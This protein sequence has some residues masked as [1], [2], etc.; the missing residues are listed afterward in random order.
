MKKSFLW[1]SA[2][3]LAV[4]LILNPVFA[5]IIAAEDDTMQ[6]QWSDNQL[7]ILRD[8]GVSETR[9]SA[10]NLTTGELSLMAAIQQAE[11]FLQ[12]RYPQQVFSFL[13]LS[14]NLL[15]GS[16]HVF[17]V[18]EQFSSVTFS[19]TAAVTDDPAMYEITES[20]Y[21]LTKAQEVND[22]LN[23]L[24][25]AKGVD[26]PKTAIKLLGEYGAAFDPAVPVADIIAQ[27]QLFVITGDVYI[28]PVDDFSALAEQLRQDLSACG[29]VGGLYLCMMDPLPEGEA[30]LSWRQTCQEQLIDRAFI[31]MSA[32][33]A[34]REE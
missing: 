2:V 22:Y 5:P 10:N 33:P 23:E 16:K 32:T 20:Y 30:D 17:D 11:A 29:F 31:S 15:S 8:S 18:E 21:T 6:T 13:R 7:Q 26:S 27:G 34:S 24:L 4:C 14:G 9:I 3:V 28:A 12:T 1:L 25:T 19:L